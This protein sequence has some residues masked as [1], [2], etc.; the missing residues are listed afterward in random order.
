MHLY[1]MAAIA[2]AA[3]FGSWQV[4]EWRYGAKEADRLEAI[5]RDRMIAEKNID[6]AAVGHEKD[7]VEIQTEFLT[8]TKEVERVIEKPFYVN[9]ELCMDDDGLRE[10]NAAR[11]PAAAASQPAPALPGPAARHWWQPSPKPE[12]PD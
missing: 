1:I 8:I 3:A 2:I 10:L 12:K 9:S 4:Q 11:A 7:K 6:T 5:K